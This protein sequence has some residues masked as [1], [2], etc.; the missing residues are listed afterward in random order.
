MYL[1]QYN[2]Q[3]LTQENWLSDKMRTCFPMSYAI[4]PLAQLCNGHDRTRQ[5][6]NTSVDDVSVDYLSVDYLSV[7]DVSA[8]DL[9]VRRVQP[10]VVKTV[11]TGN[12]GLPGP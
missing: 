10:F 12:G 8:G 3:Y 2:T 11:G 5:Q 6:G 4:N 9:Y 1:H 7:D